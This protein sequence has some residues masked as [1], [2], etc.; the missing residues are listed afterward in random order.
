MNVLVFFLLGLIGSAVAE[1][2]DEAWT[3]EMV[4]KLFSAG[5]KVDATVHGLISH[6]GYAVERHYVRTEDGYI[7]QMHRIPAIR[8]TPRSTSRGVVFLMHGLCGSSAAYVLLGPGK[9]LAYVLA[10]DG[11]DVWMGNARGNTYSKN[12]TT[13]TDFN[14][15]IF[16]NFEWHEIGIYDLPAMIDYVLE[17]TGR[18]KVSFV[19]H[20]QGATTF[21]VMTSLKPEYNDKI[22]VM[23]SLGP[24]AYMSNVISP[25]L[26]FIANFQN[27]L[28]VFLN[29]VGQYEFPSNHEFMIAASKNFCNIDALTRCLCSNLIFLLTGFHRAQ[30]NIS[31]LPTVVKHMPAGA[32]TRQ[33]IHYA[34]EV[35]S[36]KFR[37]WDYGLLCNL[38]HYGTLTPPDYELGKITA[39]VHLLYSN[40]DWM[41]STED[42]KL[43]YTELGNPI[44]MYRILDEKWNHL[45]FIFGI[46]A[47]ELV[48]DHILDVLQKRYG[49]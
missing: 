2:D 45:D 49:D 14:S 23:F 19:G 41:A 5:D 31:M 29:L 13:I 35:K 9:A 27:P 22:E 25:A 12:H 48:Y 26:R 30:T 43:L 10:D 46:D 11:H 28:G 18:D 38:W 36:G 37:Q 47:K 42:V 39:P 40:N 24:V 32:S 1:D 7:L 3:Q 21:Y 6:H 4:D 8:T 17:N 34:Q 44:E 20:S 16:W 15:K 33:L